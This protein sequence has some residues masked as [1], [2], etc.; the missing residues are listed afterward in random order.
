[1]SRSAKASTEILPFPRI[2]RTGVGGRLDARPQ[3]GQALGVSTIALHIIE[4]VKSLPSEEQEA[5]RNAL[6]G[7][8]TS[9]ARP[10]RRELQRLADGSYLNPS[11]IP[12]DDPVFRFI[13]Q[14]EE[15]RHQMPG[16]AAPAFD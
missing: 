7:Q 2:S 11:G 6:A 5:V 4:L 12:N 10:K 14:I 3:C 16:P 13:E 9:N 15:E 1:M 8:Q